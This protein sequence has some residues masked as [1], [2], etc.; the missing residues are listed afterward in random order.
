MLKLAGVLA[1]MTSSTSGASGQSEA[2]PPVNLVA[3]PAG[4]GVRVQ[5]VAASRDPYAASF[6]LE[7]TSGGN[8]SVHHGSATLAG[9]EAV[10]LSTVTLGNAAPGQWRAHLT[11]Q[12]Q[13]GPAYEQ[14]RTSF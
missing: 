2:P 6:S 7:V 3:E 4:E 9:G 5:V 11:V 1:A 12:P 10:T 14:V 8:R 13:S